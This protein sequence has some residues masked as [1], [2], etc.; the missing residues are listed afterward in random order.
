MH[1]GK[2]SEASNPILADK[3]VNVK[4]IAKIIVLIAI[5][6][7]VSG[8]PRAEPVIGGITIVNTKLQQGT[9]RP[10]CPIKEMIG[11]GRPIKGISI[12]K[13]NGTRKSIP[14]VKQGELMGYSQLQ[15]EMPL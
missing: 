10:N 11:L 6:I 4:L 3:L 15:I 5:T 7:G 1:D 12:S 14:K 13:E 8:I 9:P 2:V